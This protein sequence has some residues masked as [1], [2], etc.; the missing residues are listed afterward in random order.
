M[1]LSAFLFVSLRLKVLIMNIDTSNTISVLLKAKAIY[2]STNLRDTKAL[3]LKIARTM[4]DSI[5]VDCKLNRN[6]KKHQKLLAF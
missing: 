4:I 5:K 3:M 1:R 6:F 2:Q